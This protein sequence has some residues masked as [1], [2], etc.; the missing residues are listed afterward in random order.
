M[1]LG[2]VADLA[3][4]LGQRHPSLLATAENDLA[5]LR[6]RLA[7]VTAFIHNTDYD[8]TAR[9]ALAQALQLPE[10]TPKETPGGH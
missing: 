5:I 1:K 9:R 4:Q 7:I 2:Y 8:D 3:I 10:P 6:G